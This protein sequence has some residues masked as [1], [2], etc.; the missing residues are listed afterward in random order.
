MNTILSTAEQLQR[1]ISILENRAQQQRQELKIQF[2]RFTNALQ[3][4][5]LVADTLQSFSVNTLLS[6]SHIKSG[7]WQ[8]ALSLVTGYIS[9]KFF[10]NKNDSFLKKIAGYGLQ[11]AVTALLNKKK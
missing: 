1:S 3:P 2:N 6:E 8:S 10:I 11:W 7:L 5:N 4:K 9:R